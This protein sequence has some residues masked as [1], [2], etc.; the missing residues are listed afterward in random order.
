MKPA[1]TSPIRNVLPL[2]GII[3]LAAP[4]IKIPVAARNG[5]LNEKSKALMIL[6]PRAS[7]PPQIDPKRMMPKISFFL[8]IISHSPF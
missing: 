2:L 7:R 6:I 4:R 1:A 5:D 8:S 3:I